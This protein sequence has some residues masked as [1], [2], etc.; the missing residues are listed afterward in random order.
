[1]KSVSENPLLR[2]IIDQYKE[3]EDPEFKDPEEFQDIRMELQ[4]MGH[5]LVIFL[6]S[7]YIV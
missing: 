4:A 3:G 1:M 5:N 6:F 2:K 7:Q